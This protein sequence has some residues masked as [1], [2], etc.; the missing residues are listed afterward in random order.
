[1]AAL[2]GLRVHEIAKMR[3]EDVDLDAR[4]L[5][6]TGKGGRTD[7][8]PLHPRLVAA[9]LSM[10]TRGWW[11]PANSRRRGEHLHS[12]SVSDIIGSAMRPPRTRQ[13]RC[14]R[15]RHPGHTAFV[16]ALVRNES[17]CQRR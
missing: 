16:A 2:A 15:R 13:R 7:T 1:M 4:T 9:A 8:I 14:S 12:K 17:R 11:F 5:R 3:G 6:V 10:P